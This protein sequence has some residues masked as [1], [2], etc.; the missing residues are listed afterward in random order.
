MLITAVMHRRG[1][2]GWADPRVIDGL[3]AAMQQLILFGRE[4]LGV[5]E[6]EVDVHRMQGLA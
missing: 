2:D 5:E 6:L 3:L 4:F 1:Y